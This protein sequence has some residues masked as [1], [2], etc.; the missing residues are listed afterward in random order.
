MKNNIEKLQL[1]M[2]R[3]LDRSRPNIT[4]YPQTIYDQPDYQLKSP[5]NTDKE[6]TYNS[7]LFKNINNESQPIMD[8]GSGVSNFSS[9]SNIN[10]LLNA[11]VNNLHLSS[12]EVHRDSQTAGR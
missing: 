6:F 7:T 4:K 11:N 5:A 12:K 10:H 1:N 9:V 2:N 8:N 3:K